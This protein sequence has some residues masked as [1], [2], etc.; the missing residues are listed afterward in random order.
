[1]KLLANE[2]AYRNTYSGYEGSFVSFLQPYAAPGYIAFIKD[3]THPEMDGSYLIESTEVHF[4]VKGARR[5]IELGI[6]TDK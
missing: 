5:I 6:K 4:G 3:N 2:K 1:L